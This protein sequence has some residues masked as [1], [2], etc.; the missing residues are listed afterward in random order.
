ML[1]PTGLAI[2]WILQKRSQTTR[3]L[4]FLL[5]A[6]LA[7]GSALVLGVSVIFNGNEFQAGKICKVLLERGMNELICR[8]P[9]EVIAN[10]TAQH[11]LVTVASLARV[12]LGYLPLLGAALVPFIFL[13]LSKGIWVLIALQTF[14]IS[15]LFVIATDYG[16]WI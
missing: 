9:I 5:A 2:I 3:R 6:S 13:G 14:V 1:F 15:P 8:G 16:R 10:N 4:S 11:A 7:G 12:H